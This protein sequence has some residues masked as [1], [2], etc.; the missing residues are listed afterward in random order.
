MEFSWLGFS[1]VFG[2]N[3]T[4]TL[5]IIHVNETIF[6]IWFEIWNV[7]LY[8]NHFLLLILLKSANETK[9]VGIPKYSSF[10]LLL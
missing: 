1:L 4:L 7:N 8:Y 5:K 6:W 2:C 3:I 10:S 9:F